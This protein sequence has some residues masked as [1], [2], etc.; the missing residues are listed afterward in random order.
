MEM[1]YFK[2]RCASLAD[3]LDPR[4]GQA[5]P[6]RLDPVLA[7]EIE[8]CALGLDGFRLAQDVEDV[9]GPN[10]F[11]VPRAHVHAHQD[12]TFLNGGLG[13]GAAGRDC[14]DVQSA[15]ELGRD[16]RN[17]VGETGMGLQAE[18]LPDL[19]NRLG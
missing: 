8:N 11:P 15:P 10:R 3:L 2:S 16:G 5:D 1:R 4:L 13:C 19:I 17:P 18:D 6:A 7:D 9:V 14:L 12:V